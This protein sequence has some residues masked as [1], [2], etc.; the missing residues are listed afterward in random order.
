[1]YRE[2]NLNELV[3]PWIPFLSFQSRRTQ[4]SNISISQTNKHTLFS[5]CPTS[6]HSYTHKAFFLFIMDLDSHLAAA[7]QHLNLSDAGVEQPITNSST[8]INTD[9]DIDIFASHI[10]PQ[11]NFVKRSNKY[12][13]ISVDQM[14]PLNWD[15]GRRPNRPFDHINSDWLSILHSFSPLFFPSSPPRTPP[16][17]P[18]RRPQN[19]YPTAYYLEQAPFYS[20]ISGPDPFAA[21][22]APVRPGPLKVFVYALL[23]ILG[24]ICS[25]LLSVGKNVGSSLVALLRLVIS[26][27]LWPVKVFVGA[28]AAVEWKWEVVLAVTL[29]AQLVRLLP[30]GD[31]GAGVVEREGRGGGPVYTVFVAGRDAIGNGAVMSGGG[32]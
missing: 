28:V 24:W 25:P 22:P 23:S 18:G 1:M 13:K 9:T 5:D 6:N 17:R 21:D 30:G 7:V 19:Q 29:A 31:V 32:F 26:L 12:F 4:A 27:L 10:Y 11:L 2:P 14:D 3:Q 20:Q 8:N 15:T 16:L